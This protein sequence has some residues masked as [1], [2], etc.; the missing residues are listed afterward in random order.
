MRRGPTYGVR[1]EP[2][3]ASGI[4]AASN[5]EVIPIGEETLNVGT[6][7]VAGETTRVRRMVVE[8]PVEQGICPT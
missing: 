1:S 3:M 7:R 4:E 8:T 5:V 2:A 6:R